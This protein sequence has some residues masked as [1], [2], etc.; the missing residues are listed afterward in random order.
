MIVIHCLPVGPSKRENL[1]INDDLLGDNLTACRLAAKD[2]D[3]LLQGVDTAT[4]DGVDLV[5]ANLLVCAH[6]CDTCRSSVL[7]V[8]TIVPELPV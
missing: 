1:L 2:V 3:T 7:A 5:E 4:V 6:R 8:L